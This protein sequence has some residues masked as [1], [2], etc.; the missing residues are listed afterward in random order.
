MKKNQP[1][2]DHPQTA[3]RRFVVVEM[4]Q[5]LIEYNLFIHF[6]FTAAVFN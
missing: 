1:A 4:T 5:Y 6:N 2:T 3:H